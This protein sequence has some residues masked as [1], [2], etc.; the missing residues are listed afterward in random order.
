M[1]YAQSLRNNNTS[2]SHEEQSHPETPSSSPSTPQ[3]KRFWQWLGIGGIIAFAIFFFGRI[4]RNPGKKQDSLG[5][6]ARIKEEFRE[7][8]E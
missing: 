6:V 4:S 2:S 7:K 1:L 8:M 5:N 3:R